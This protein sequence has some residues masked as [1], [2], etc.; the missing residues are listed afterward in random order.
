[1]MSAA[2]HLHIDPRAMEV[3]RGSVLDSAAFLWALSEVPLRQQR[4]FVIQELIEALKWP[5]AWPK[6]SRED[7]AGEIAD[8]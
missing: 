3:V 2:D 7:V 1:M 4:T 6:A 8:G 5:A